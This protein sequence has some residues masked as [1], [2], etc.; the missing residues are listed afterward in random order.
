MHKM[1]IT[2]GRFEHQETGRRATR[3]R[4]SIAEVHGSFLTR[5]RE[6]EIVKED[7]F[8]S[9]K[10]HSLWLS[11]VRL[12]P[13]DPQPVLSPSH[14]LSLPGDALPQEGGS[15]GPTRELSLS[16]WR[17][18]QNRAFPTHRVEHSDRCR[19]F[20]HIMELIDS[21]RQEEEGSCSYEA[22]LMPYLHKGDV[23]GYEGGSTPEKA[24]N[25]KRPRASVR[26]RKS[27]S[28]EEVDVDFV[29]PGACAP[30]RR[31]SARTPELP[32]TLIKEKTLPGSDGMDEEPGSGGHGGQTVLGQ[33]DRSETA[34]P[35]VDWDSVQDDC[36]VIP[37]ED[38][39]DEEEEEEVVS[40]TAMEDVV[41]GRWCHSPDRRGGAGNPP[42][43]LGPFSSDAGY[44]SLPDEPCPELGG[45]FYLPQWDVADPEP[46]PLPGTQEKVRAILA[47]VRD[48]LSRPPPPPPPPP[49]PDP[50]CCLSPSFDPEAKL[51]DGRTPPEPEEWGSPFAV[52]FRLEVEGEEE[53][54]EEELRDDP[55]SE[56]GSEGVPLDCQVRDGSPTRMETVPCNGA[57]EPVGS[58]T[59]SPGWG[60]VFDD[61]EEA[62]DRTAEAAGHEWEEPSPRPGPADDGLKD[63][64]ASR[65][66]VPD[67]SMDLF[68]DD[69]DDDFLRV[70]LPE[71]VEGQGPNDPRP[72]SPPGA[73]RRPS[74]ITECFD[75]SQELFSVN[76]DLGYSI[77]DSEDEEQEEE[78]GPVGGTREVSH[79]SAALPHRSAVGPSPA[80]PQERFH[81]PVNAR[82]GP[83]QGSVSTPLARRVG[84]GD[85]P[86]RISRVSSL[87]SPIV[88]GPR[89]ASHSPG[90]PT[91]EHSGAVSAGSTPGAHA[92]Q[93]PTIRRSLLRKGGSFCGRGLVNPPPGPGSSDSE[94]EMVVRGRG[95]RG[96]NNPLTSPAGK[97][98][99]DLDSPLHTTRKRAAALSS[100]EES[101]IEQMSD[102]DFQ[103]VSVRLPKAPCPRELPA[104][105]GRA[106]KAVGGGARRFLDEEAELSDE[107][108]AVSSDE[109]EEE[110]HDH[111]LGGFVVDTT[112]LSQGLNDSEM[113]SVYLKSVRSPAVY[114]KYKMVFKAR[115]NMDIFSQVPE[116]DETYGEDSFVV[117]GSEEEEDEEEEEEE[118]EEPVLVPEE[119]YVEGKRLYPTRRRARLRQARDRAREGQGDPVHQPPMKT[120]RSRIVRLDD[121][122]EEEEEEEEEDGKRKKGKGEDPAPLLL[123]GPVQASLEERGRQSLSVQTSVSGA[124]D[125][126]LLL[127]APSEPTQSREEE[128]REE[129]EEEE[130]EEG[131]GEG[132]GELIP[133]ESFIE[134]RKTKRSRNVR[135]DESGEEEEDGKRKKGK[136][137]DPAP[138]LLSRPVQTPG[139]A[140][141]GPP[142]GVPPSSLGTAAL[143]RRRGP[144]GGS[145]EERGRQSLS[146]QTSVS[147]ARDGQL[148]L[149]APSEPTQVCT[150]HNPHCVSTP[151]L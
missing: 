19:H 145:L 43:V 71:V 139:D 24:T 90:R 98:T 123:S 136:G 88:P 108:G 44:G 58:T 80:R 22:E 94:E 107:G 33:T 14:F 26:D 110:E 8:L 16:E 89:G 38:E 65:R 25:P 12:G 83:R 134:G 93:V 72:A 73:H 92:G 51:V 127:A 6:S 17:H 122:S 118:E 147:G 57:A 143:G 146:V 142:Q 11:R 49:D 55:S 130:E 101:E 64:D 111:S 133:E 48:F 117:H 132:E 45:L 104:P 78:P 79:H 46:Q 149:S 85:G 47:N 69:D 77:E 144:E 113:R 60:E 4:R 150:Q 23:V 116:Q 52:N 75:C 39:E 109:E 20:I 106:K 30:K 95:R 140:P 137:E 67:E 50:D 124:R 105:Q 34:V 135:L 114:S 59:S 61:V 53:E 68:G 99:S 100:S 56:H 42:G 13:D 102:Q 40:A 91:S 131:V 9:P 87:L 63:P 115:N 5:G 141:S 37:D 3:G 125:G 31:A 148:L 41:D 103:D 54:E 36:I 128:S 35:D 82:D 32:W 66:T 2:C 112:Q 28:V 21:M 84:S 86:P 74:E 138:L 126:Q 129:E 10:E 1:F 70:S 76:F 27:S 29:V 81:W 18:W 7:G 120:K 151:P 96:K 97:I 121:S 15:A 62:H 119:S